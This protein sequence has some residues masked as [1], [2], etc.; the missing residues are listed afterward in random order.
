MD[1]NGTQPRGGG[2]IRQL[3]GMR[4]IAVLLVL[5]TTPMF[6]LRFT[7]VLLPVTGGWG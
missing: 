5:F 4:G 6:I 3:D 1:L 7:W 2:R